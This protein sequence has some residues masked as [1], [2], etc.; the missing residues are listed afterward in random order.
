MSEALT[1]HGGIQLKDISVV[2][3]DGGTISGYESGITGLEY[4]VIDSMGTASG[5][6]AA[7]ETRALSSDSGGGGW[8][9][10]LGFSSDSGGG[11]DVGG[12]SCGS[13]CG[14]GGCGG[15]GGGCGG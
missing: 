10:N 11:A 3:P 2:I 15:C 7:L 9:A 13:S 1:D 8:L 6:G 5:A 12:S 4:G 14:G